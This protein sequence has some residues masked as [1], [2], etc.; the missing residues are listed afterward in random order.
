MPEPFTPEQ[1]QPILDKHGLSGEVHYLGSGYINWVYAVGDDTIV[2]ATK[3]GMDPEDSYTEAVAVPAARAAGVR[4][5]ELLVFDDDRDAIDTVVTVYE[6]AEGV[7]LGS[8]R[9]DQSE[10][11]SLY[12]EFGREVGRLHT[13][14]K[15]VDDPKGWL[16]EQYDYKLQEEIDKA[17]EMNRLETVSYDWLCRWAQKLEPAVQSEFDKRFIHNDMHA[18]NT[19]VLTDPLRLS[20]II[21]WGDAC[22]GDPAQ[23]IVKTPVWAAPWSIEGYREEGGVVDELFVGRVI[24]Q[25]IGIAMDSLTGGWDEIGNTPWEP[26]SSCFFINLVRLM[27]M[28]LPDEWKPWLPDSPV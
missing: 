11:P 10:L 23:D 16:D 5:P 13:G 25:N 27:A 4:T 3:Q 28:D 22:W 15:E 2:R 12:R 26:M 18:A 17:F 1:L 9:V 8:L 21:D 7:P 20:A 6:R 24:V 19:M 14:A